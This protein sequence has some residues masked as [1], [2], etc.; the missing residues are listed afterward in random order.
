MIQR[1]ERIY[2]DTAFHPGRRRV[3]FFPS[4]RNRNVEGEQVVVDNAA[5][6]G[7]FPVLWSKPVGGGE[8]L[9]VMLINIETGETAKGRLSEADFLKLPETDI[10]W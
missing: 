9:V 10:E 1:A 2:T 8:R 7:D 5:W 6:V 3:K 4:V